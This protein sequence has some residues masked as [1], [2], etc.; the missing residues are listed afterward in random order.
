M[1]NVTTEQGSFCGEGKVFHEWDNNEELQ[2][3]IS[4][5]AEGEQGWIKVPMGQSGTKH[6]FHFRVIR[7]GARFTNASWDAGDIHWISGFV[8][9][10]LGQSMTR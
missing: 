5:M 2:Q 9:E 3:A 7:G 1:I 8:G 10:T 6:A 4:E